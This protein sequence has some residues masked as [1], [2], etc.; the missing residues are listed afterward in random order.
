MDTALSHELD[1][2]RRVAARVED[3]AALN[4]L[5]DGVA[6][7]VLA[8]YQLEDRGRDHGGEA[9]GRTTAKRRRVPCNAP[10]FSQLD[11]DP[12]PLSLDSR[13][14]AY[15]CSSHKNTTLLFTLPGGGSACP[16]VRCT[17]CLFDGRGTETEGSLSLPPLGRRRA[18]PTSTAGGLGHRTRAFAVL[19]QSTNVLPQSTT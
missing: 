3:F 16:S 8:F 18:L 2:N 6:V 15:Y 4:F 17:L 12:S 9:R 11:D 7:R 19:P 5:D 1:L 14:V 10:D 13:L